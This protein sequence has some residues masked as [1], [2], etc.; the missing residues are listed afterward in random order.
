MEMLNSAIAGD[1]YRVTAANADA[2]TGAAFLS[3]SG[4]SL[5]IASSNPSPTTLTLNLPTTGA[6]P[7]QGFS[8]SA[9][10]PTATNDVTVNNATGTPQ[11]SIVPITLAGNQITIPP[12]GLVVLLPAGAPAP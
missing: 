12:Y 1:F 2:I 5:A 3:S 7:S 8:L 9:E 10:T 4:W 6:A 11:V